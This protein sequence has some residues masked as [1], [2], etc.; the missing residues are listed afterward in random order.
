MLHVSGSNAHTSI[1]SQLKIQGCIFFIKNF[2]FI[3][4]YQG[5]AN[6]K[7]LIIRGGV[8]YLTAIVHTLYGC[9]MDV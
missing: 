1:M 2:V 9:C 6:F 8:F 5:N 4:I 3:N 7:S